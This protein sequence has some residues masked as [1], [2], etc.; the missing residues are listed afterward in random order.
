M[1]G[2]PS[3]KLRLR[4]GK[5]LANT[6]RRWIS[7]EHN[8]VISE[9]H[10][11]SYT[12]TLGTFS[13]YRCQPSGQPIG[14]SI[15]IRNQRMYISKAIQ[16]MC[17]GSKGWAFSAVLCTSYTLVQK[18]TCWHHRHWNSCANISRIPTFSSAREGRGEWG[19]N[20]EKKRVEERICS[21]HACQG[22]AVCGQSAFVGSQW[23][24]PDYCR[25]AHTWH[26]HVKTVK[27]CLGMIERKACHLFVLV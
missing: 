23:C 25:A 5:W 27:I 21:K 12:I 17:L 3:F 1:N 19:R 8:R 2:S 7:Q 13:K 14:Q 16:A 20:R 15:C 26:E 11:S 4:E 9:F 22:E 18:H 24:Q 6:T 10:Y